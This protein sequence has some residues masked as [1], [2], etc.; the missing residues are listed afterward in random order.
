MSLPKIKKECK[1]CNCW[2]SSNIN[3]YKC[4]TFE[5]PIYQIN[6]SKINE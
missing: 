5:C 4:T 2:D 6:K 1:S 3:H